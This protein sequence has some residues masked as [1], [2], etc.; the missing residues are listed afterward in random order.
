MSIAQLSVKLYVAEPRDL[1]LREFV[2]TFHRW[3]QDER[4]DEL[5]IDV[6]D[7]SHVV[8]GPGVLLVCHEAQYSMDGGDGRLGLRYARKRGGTGTLEDR[9][10]QALRK[11]L[12]ACQALADDPAL[13]GGIAFRTDEARLVFEDRLAAP[14]TPATF[15]D[16]APGLTRLF[17]RMFGVEPSLEHRAR[18]DECFGLDVRAPAAPDLATLLARLG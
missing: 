3:I 14:N 6:T 1:E 17:E 18:P 16:V 15:A 7:Y 11:A 9:V 13:A 10:A 4:L 12:T 8:G 5:L 2:G